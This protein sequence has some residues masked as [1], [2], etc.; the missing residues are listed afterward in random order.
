MNLEKNTTFKD[1]DLEDIYLWL[2]QKDA[3]TLDKKTLFYL[4]EKSIAELKNWL[5]SKSYAFKEL[6]LLKTELEQSNVKELAPIKKQLEN[7]IYSYLFLGI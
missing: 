3:T 2:E 1:F 6:A 7:T 5:S 4:I